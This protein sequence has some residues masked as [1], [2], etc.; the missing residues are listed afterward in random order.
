MGLTLRWKTM[1]DLKRWRSKV[2]SYNVEGDASV[3]DVPVS[4]TFDD[5]WSCMGDECAQCP[6]FVLL[7]QFC[8]VTECN[9][10]F[11]EQTTELFAI[12]LAEKGHPGARNS[13]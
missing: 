5:T 1:A 11:V 10:G 12:L 9:S 13:S 7:S 4:V 6:L 8:P 3:C 2:C